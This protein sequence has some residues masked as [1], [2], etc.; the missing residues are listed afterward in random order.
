MGIK[1]ELTRRQWLWKGIYFTE[2][3]AAKQPTLPAGN[4][5]S[6]EAFSIGAAPFRKKSAS[7]ADGGAE[8]IAL[9]IIAQVKLRGD[10]ALRE[11]AQKFDR[12]GEDYKIRVGKEEVKE[13]YSKVDKKA[14]EAMRLAIKNQEISSRE[15]MPKRAVAE[16][17]GAEVEQVFTP[18][19][20]IG[21]YAPGG[22]AA[23]P[24]S[25]IM[26]AIPAK[27][28]G[29]ES[30]CLCSPPP[31]SPAVLVA[32]DLCGIGDIFAVGGAQAIA[33]MAYGTKTIMKVDK[34]AGPG[35]K[36][37][38]AA[39]NL[40]RGISCDIDMPAGPSEVLIVADE[41]A[42]AS[43]VAQ[44][45]LAQLEH[46]PDAIAVLVCGKENAAKIM[47]EMG[48]L[49]KG[50]PRLAIIKNAAEN[51]YIVLADTADAKMVAEFVNGFAP[52]H[53]QLMCANAEELLLLV[54][55]AGSTFVGV[56]TCTA[57]GDYCAGSNHVLPTGG[58]AKFASS[59]SVLSFLKAS[60]IV[61][62][63][64]GNALFEK[65]A[66]FAKAEGLSAHASS[67]KMRCE[68]G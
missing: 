23:Y 31:I 17:D 22:R 13:A 2:T 33:A 63:N 32:A 20:R 26:A 49:A 57:I 15:F 24:S 36:Y 4:L 3:K 51:S 59:L 7:G 44:D 12:Q 61:R 16:T 39:K 50:E 6:L 42:N 58:A 35:N 30:I 68:D 48:R 27:V 45:L 67:A 21:I 64:D 25:V 11:Y 40:V 9:E 14:I 29:V 56:R 5:F 54:K 65:T 37:V 62:A 28:A 53:L 18:V 43:W 60:T 34:I 10:E 19:G 66:D 52:E 47:S 38:L 55:N 1:W 41:S 46:D 8:K